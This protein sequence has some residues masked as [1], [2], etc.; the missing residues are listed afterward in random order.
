MIIEMT[1]NLGITSL[2]NTFSESITKDYDSI[3]DVGYKKKIIRVDHYSNKIPVWDKKSLI[4]AVK[5][6]RNEIVK[7]RKV[8]IYCDNSVSISV[9]VSMLYLMVYEHNNYNDIINYDLGT[10]PDER[11]NN[12]IK[13]EFN[14]KDLSKLFKNE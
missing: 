1:D 4:S 7:G 11:I 2:L 14:K 10:E 12:I 9:C 5:W 8:L 6:I 3:L 13:T